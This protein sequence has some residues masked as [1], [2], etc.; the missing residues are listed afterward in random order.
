MFLSKKGFTLIEI[1]FVIAIISLL[2]T[3]I[4]QSVNDARHKAE[5]AK[6]KEQ[7]RQVRDAIQNYR[8]DYGQL[9]SL[10]DDHAGYL[11]AMTEL[12]NT[13]YITEEPDLENIRKV[14][15]TRV[16]DP[17][18]VVS[19]SGT[20][21]EGNDINPEFQFYFRYTGSDPHL[22]DGVFPR[23]LYTANGQHVLESFY[24]FFV[25]ID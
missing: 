16:N 4:V 23:L 3:I 21:C 12:K 10:L 18:F 25:P 1:M 8:E 5:V 17:R 22:Y 20:Y 7:F 14:L 9:P 13:G 15:E 11:A 6:I 24:C 19:S 2:S